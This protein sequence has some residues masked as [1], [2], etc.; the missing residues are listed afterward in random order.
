[1]QRVFFSRQIQEDRPPIPCLLLKSNSDGEYTFLKIN[2]FFSFSCRCPILFVPVMRFAIELFS[3]FLSFFFFRNLVRFKMFLSFLCVSPY[4]TDPFFQQMMFLP[5]MVA[6]FSSSL[7]V[8]M[9]SLISVPVPFFTHPCRCFLNQG[10]FP[11]RAFQEAQRPC[12]GPAW[13]FQ[14]GS[15][16][17]R[18][19]TP[20]LD[21]MRR[22]P[23]E[24]LGKISFFINVDVAMAHHGA[25]LLM[26]DFDFP[27]FPTDSGEDVFFSS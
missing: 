20:L 7:S 27:F 11:N 9:T 21:A 1:M 2:F 16:F 8:S 12:F 26:Q 6:L 14:D 3:Y 18:S 5:W 13:V 19:F 4:T 10:A 17:D 15:I 24:F 25:P 22:M 23:C